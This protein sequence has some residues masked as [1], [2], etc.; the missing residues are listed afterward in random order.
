MKAI[1]L[2]TLILLTELNLRPRL[3][4][5]ERKL[6]LFYGLTQ[7]NYIVLWKL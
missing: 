6:L 1:I 3:E 2:L 4:R 7:R 5:A